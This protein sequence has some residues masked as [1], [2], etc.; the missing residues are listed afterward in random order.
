MWYKNNFRRHLC[1]MHIN[2]WN[3]AFLSE[4]SPENYVENLKKAKIQN[5]MLYFQSHVGLCNYPTNS[6]K[7]HNA[8]RG[9]EDAMKCVADM[10]HDEGIAVTGYY[11]LI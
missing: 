1:Y 5:A 11:S 8:F 2:D 10:C 9:S 4:F 3:D 7:M 6:G